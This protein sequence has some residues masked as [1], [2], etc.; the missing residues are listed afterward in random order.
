MDPGQLA[1]TLLHKNFNKFGT[2]LTSVVYSSITAPTYSATT[3]VVTPGTDVDYNIDV[4]MLP[5][6]MTKNQSTFR[7][8]DNDVIPSLDVKVLFPAL[9]LAAV[10]KVGDYV[11]KSAGQVW[12]VIGV[13][14]DPKP[15]HWNLHCRAQI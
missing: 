3:G 6:S 7:Y 8:N 9:S 15:A 13:N 5:F 12:K 2:F 1:A 4:A 11:T 14:S 10:P